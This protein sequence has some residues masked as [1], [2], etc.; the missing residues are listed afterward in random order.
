VRPL[1]TLASVLLA[2]GSLAVLASPANAASGRVDVIE[3]TGLIDPVEVDFIAHAIGDAEAAGAE[4]LVVQLN[5]GGA[6][7]SDARLATLTRRL[8][9]AR[10]PVAVWIGPTG[11]EGS[12]GA[13][14]IARAAGVVG[15]AP[16]ASARGPV[17]GGLRVDAP[18][19]GDFIVGLDG[20]RVRGRTLDTAR[21]VATPAGP[22]RQPIGVRFAKPALLPRLL[23]TVASPSVAYLL[24]V[25][26]LLLI[27]FEFFT[28]GIGVAG[29][30]GAGSLVLA[31]YGASVL[32][33][34]PLSSGLLA[35][36]VFGFAVDVQAG[37]PRAW[38]V[39][40]AVALLVGSFRLYDGFVVPW[41]TVLLVAAG[42]ALF[43]VAGM[44]AMLRARFS[45]PTIGRESMIGELGAAAAAV[46]P[47]G[48]ITLRGALW[49]ARTNRAT[50][51]A[52]GDTVR[53]V[54]IDGL[55]LEVEPE[56]G[57]AR[58]PRH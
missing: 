50:P 58:E 44:P 14:Q 16:G 56:S 30:S 29:A 31:L 27:V 23:H 53:V 52:A 40:G 49:R 37:A 24:F 38:T 43:M 42:V 34:R 33:T 57:G 26:G 32:P 39:I 36:G 12:G 15:V 10:V 4:A 17:G 35:L 3:V 6:V 51:I 54:A 46:D 25:A 45:T 19:L 22:R 5:S 13:L 47:E 48:T 7:V 55:V 20:L 9:V 41:W 8:R 28:A 21:V 1:R 18:V 2:L 11:A